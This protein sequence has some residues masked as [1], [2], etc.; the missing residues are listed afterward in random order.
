MEAVIPEIEGP[1]GYANMS[2][3]MNTWYVA[4]GSE[5]ITTEPLSRTLL[6]RPLVFFR[7]DRGR[8]RALGNICPH[9]FAKLS[10]GKV[11]GDTIE[12]PYHGLRFDKTG[13]C[14][15]NPHGDGS[16][17]PRA[18]VEAY[19]LEERHG[20]FWI[21]MGDQ[22]LADPSM[23]PDYSALDEAP[24]ATSVG[25]MMMGV[26][27]KLIL[28]N[29]MDLSHVEYL[30]AAF[31]SPGW[32]AKRKSVVQQ[33]DRAVTCT[34]R[35][36]DIAITPF[37]AYLKPDAVTIG[38]QRLDLT[39]TAPSNIFLDVQF[40][41][42]KEVI[43]TPITHTLT[44]ENESSTHYFFRQTRNHLTEDAAF[45]RN[46]HEMIEN[47]FRSEDEPMIED[48]QQHLGNMD[49]M[50]A[51]PVILQSDNAAIRVRRLLA[52]LVRQ[53]Q[54]GQG[55]GAVSETAMATEQV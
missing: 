1:K 29:L 31:A 55:A 14:I 22:V 10:K 39:W 50:D 12:C 9:R 48:Q 45:T 17:P 33:L 6:D 27:Y 30:H 41:T 34:N 23:I 21:W 46:V 32:V 24:L 13:A 43:S 3:L 4:A 11:V 38:E 7:D 19:A 8:G 5:E 52:Q 16:I 54:Q 20:L 44:P 26:N 37:H 25:H 28:D 35:A 49:L 47:V 53:E 15:F 18:R 51:R 40:I 42:D 36:Q 2:Y